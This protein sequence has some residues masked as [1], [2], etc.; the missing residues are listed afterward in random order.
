[1]A[2]SL[3][4][5]PVPDPPA[6]GPFPL[7][8]GWGGGMDADIPIVTHS[9][10]QDEL[11]KEQRF[12]LG[13]GA[14]RFRVRFDRLACSE[15]D[16]LQSHWIQARGVYAQFSY[17][18]WRNTV[19][20]ETVT[21]RYE[22]PTISFSQL[23][24]MIT[25]GMGL[26]LLE[27]PPAA[28][29]Y[30]SVATLTRFP[31]TAFADALTQ[32]TQR[33][34]PLITIQPRRKAVPPETVDPDPLYISNQRV[35][36]DGISYLPRLLDWG[37]ISQSIGESSDSARFTFGNAD[38]IWTDY[39]NQRPLDKA[40][41]SF[42]LFHVE[43]RYL[44]RLWSGYALPWEADNEGHFYLNAA[45][46]A[47]ELALSYPMRTVTRACWK[48]YKGRYCP[49][50]SPLTTCQKSWE[51]CVERGVPK[52]FGGMVVAPNKVRVKDNSTGTWG[53]GRSSLT[54]VTVVDDT[55]YQRPLQ[56]IYTDKDMAVTCDV[57]AGRD[58]SDF[59][60]ALGIVGEGPVSGYSTDL[61]RHRLDAQ[62]PHDPLKPQAGW[63]GIPGNDPAGTQDFFALDQA[64]WNVPP[65]G[66]T[67]AGG[68][69]F[70]EIRRSDEKGLQL[71]KVSDRAMSVVVTG[72]IGGWTW[73]A[74]GA[75]VWKPA[76]SNFVWVAVNVYLR[77]IGL[78]ADEAR[79]GSIS[80]AEMEKHFDVNQA[81]SMATLA[82][83]DVPK[84][85][86]VGT[87][88]QYAFRGVLKERK[89]LKDWL[90]EICNC[91]LGYFTFV[92]GKLWIGIRNDSS[93]LAGNA[94]TRDS[95]LFKSL[96][97]APHKPQFNWLTGQ[98]GDD[99]FDFQL[100][101]V[102]VYDITHAQRIGTPDSPEY[103]SSTMTFVGISGKSQCARVVTTRLREELGGA[104]ETEQI[105]ARDI[106]FRTTVLGLRTLAGDVISLNHARL[107]GGQAR[108]TNFRCQR[109][110]LNPDWSIDIEASPSTDSMYDY[111]F[112]PKPDDVPAPPIII[113]ALPSINGLTWMPNEVGP[114]TDATGL[115]SLD[116][117]YKDAKQRTF[118]VWQDY[119]ITRDGNWDAAIWVAGKM[120]VNK[121]AEGHQPRILGAQLAAGGTL[122][123][124]LTV[125]AA[126]TQ[127][128]SANATPI[129]PSNLTGIWIPSGLSNQKVVLTVSPSSDT[130][131][132]WDLWVGNDRRAISLQ[133]ST[134]GALPT[135]VDVAGPIH[136]MTEGLPEAAARRIAIA[137]KHVWHSGIAGV[138][139]NEVFS[140]NRIQSNDFIGS[141]DNWIG[142]YVSMLADQSDGAAPLWN[143]K[144]IGFDPSNG[145]MSL[146]PECVIAGQPQNS[147]EPGDVMI[148][149]SQAITST[150]SSIT[151]PM[152]DNSVG[153]A[154]F[155]SPGLEPGQEV[156]RIYRI[157]FGAGAGQHRS[158]VG[159]DATSIQV[160]PPFDPPPGPDSIGIVEAAD[161]IYTAR[162]SELITERNDLRVEI[163]MRVDNLRDRVALV[164][165]FLVDDQDRLSDELVAPMREIYIF[166]QPP[167]VR[168]IGPAA[169]P[170][171]SAATDHTIR[172][173][174]SANDVT[175]NLSP[176]YVYQGRTL[177][178]VNDNGPNNLIVN[179]AAGESLFDGLTTV[180]VAP[181]ESMKV[182]A[183]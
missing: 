1:M 120:A 123:G 77:A 155:G 165:G 37:G 109:W 74:P 175:L 64:P 44:V 180:T 173:D 101:N 140:P 12:V 9:F 99:E 29:P 58:E 57:A 93:V 141:T 177:Y 43:S 82:D 65:P 160:H 20:K 129:P 158:I 39:V 112:G 51:D 35:T 87:E 107:P 162:T 84:M 7:R 163:R 4:P 127:R 111:T 66:A 13:D 46:G 62:P 42:A 95:I 149:R 2:G 108:Q 60:S 79:G 47:F 115:I 40:K 122:T 98:F 126:I 38:G 133:S 26:T 114:K 21:V 151:D 138:L 171:E 161:W 159:N 137:A 121:L 172:A 8:S 61:I 48:V 92:D 128:P 22:N 88:R 104:T 135:S 103:H 113:G 19:S 86:G 71:S 30:T 100:N 181:F 105:E 117:F 72:G 73:T 106:R 144:I 164:G 150:A 10:D 50:T 17:D 28:P 110:T 132:Q 142:R 147:V 166:G 67:Y 131:A 183:G 119:A 96:E 5:I 15:Y 59:Y 153:R 27:I 16:Q 124:P 33:L 32:Q 116:P 102:T 81:V 90:Q 136:P 178:L 174:T 130:M 145:Q 91:G 80:P 156:G 25:G 139:V 54:S 14:R 56:E 3:G 6:I 146:E 78:R 167:T 89:P 69:A 24:G 11:R 118:D 176:L 23:V 168:V 170:W 76:L 70:A 75:R 36:V 55:V 169:G 31:D 157:L 63:R 148:V 41:I 94:Y 52:S 34:I 182:T 49:S 68:L 97:I 152:W 45:D 125:Y 154:Q 134:A 143:Y 83:L 53:W 85:I 179:C 18:Y